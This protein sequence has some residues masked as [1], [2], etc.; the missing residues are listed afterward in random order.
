MSNA[1]S[2]YGKHVKIT[3]YINA[4][5]AGENLTRLIHTG[6]PVFVN[7]APIIWYSKRQYN[8]ESS[9]FEFNVVALRTDLKFIKMFCYKLH[10]MG[11]SLSGAAYVFSDN[12]GI[13]NALSNPECR[14][15]NNHLSIF[16]H[17]ACTASEQG[18]WRVGY[19]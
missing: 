14:I 11:V 10:M 2:T 7:S 17:T 8:I 6:I 19:I 18:I 1:P 15:T 13:V 12:K 4:D 5:H 9:T 16:Y 3:R